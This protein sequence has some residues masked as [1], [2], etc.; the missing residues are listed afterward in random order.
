MTGFFVTLMSGIDFN[1]GDSHA[2]ARSYVKGAVRV[3]RKGGARQ[4]FV[5]EV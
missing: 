5:N 1:K 4:D 2:C 3:D